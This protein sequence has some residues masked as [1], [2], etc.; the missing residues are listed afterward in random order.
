VRV[1]EIIQ[2]SVLYGNLSFVWRIPVFRFV[3][4]CGLMWACYGFRAAA[5]SHNSEKVDSKKPIPTNQP[6]NLVYP[7]ARRTK[8]KNTMAGPLFFGTQLPLAAS[9]SLRKLSCLRT[10][11][12][13]FSAVSKIDQ[14]GRKL[15]VIGNCQYTNSLYSNL[16]NTN[17]ISTHSLFSNS[18]F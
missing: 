12:P 13:T 16:F 4:A 9:R 14:F 1:G 3:S 17:K 15:F 10:H 6:T 2:I 5:L 18:T 11:F 7:R 8:A